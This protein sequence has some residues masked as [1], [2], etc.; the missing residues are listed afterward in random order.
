MLGPDGG[1]QEVIISRVK[2][3][4]KSV[5][6]EEFRQVGWGHVMKG[7]VGHEKFKWILWGMG[8]QWSL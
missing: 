7:F 6:M 5:L 4:G 8:S 1:G 3:V 2:G